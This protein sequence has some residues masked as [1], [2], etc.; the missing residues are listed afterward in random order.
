[1]KCIIIVAGVR[2]PS[3]T[4]DHNEPP[5]HGKVHGSM[6]D[7]RRA[8]TES[9]L[10]LRF[11]CDFTAKHRLAQWLSSINYCESSHLFDIYTWQ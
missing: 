2:D 8:T 1:M 3:A 5:P 10:S 7:N 11:Y 9:S 4:S 6:V